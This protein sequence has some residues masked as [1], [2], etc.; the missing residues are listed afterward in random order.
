MAVVAAPG[1]RPDGTAR[2]ELPYHGSMAGVKRMNLKTLLRIAAGVG[3][4][5]GA[6]ILTGCGPAWYLDPEFAERLARQENKPLLLYFKAWDSSGHR[7][8]KLQVLDSAAVKSELTETVNAEIEFAFYPQWRQRY[9]V[10]AP[11]VCIMCAPDGRPVEKPLSV[12]QVPSKEAFV[13]W[14]R[15]TKALAKPSSDSKPPPPR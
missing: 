7:N 9:G 2:L 5:T 6:A 3:L 12:N 14:L 15:R 1:T 11:Q 4:V 13:E 8:L 10:T